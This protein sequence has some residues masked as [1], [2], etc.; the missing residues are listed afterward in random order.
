VILAARMP[1]A[2]LVKGGSLRHAAAS[3]LTRRAKTRILLRCEHL[4]ILAR[5][6]RRATPH[7]RWSR[8][9]LSCS[10]RPD[11]LVGTFFLNGLFL[12]NVLGASPLT[13][14]PAFLPL[15]V[16][17]GIAA[18]LTPH[19]P[20]RVGAHAVTVSGLAMVAGG[21][22]VLSGALAHA[23]PLIDVLPG[24]LLLG[25]GIGLMFVAIG[26]SISSAV[27]LGSEPQ[28][29]PRLRTAMA[30]ALWPVPSL[31]RRSLLSLASP[32]RHS[33]PV[34]VHQAAVP[35]RFSSQ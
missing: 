14:G 11:I 15:V 31:Q 12:Q 33:R 32:S 18:H 30:R 28:A 27:A 17:I 29:W 20:T 21:E 26:V 19:L 10:A 34:S 8:S 5:L 13:T 9:P 25:F 35:L 22:L 7:A 6:Q 3:S 16:V 4:L 23:T 24:F 2:R 1:G